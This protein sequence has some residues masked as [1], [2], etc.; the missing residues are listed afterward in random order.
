MTVQF[1]V[2]DSVCVSMLY[3]GQQCTVGVWRAP[4]S[5]FSQTESS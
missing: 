2:G 4:L 1:I 5:T 3:N